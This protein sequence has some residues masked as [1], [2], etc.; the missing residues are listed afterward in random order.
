MAVA[1]LPMNRIRIRPGRII[2]WTLLLIGG[3]IMITP[4]F[5]MFS[6]SLK[7][8][9]QV[10]DRVS[11]RRTPRSTTMCWRSPTASSCAGC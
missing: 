11:S 10:Y 2:A 5:Y 9:A 7:N 1:E 3:L 6:T 8:S 4:L